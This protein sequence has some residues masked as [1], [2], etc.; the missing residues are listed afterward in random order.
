[1]KKAIAAF[2]TAVLVIGMA[3]SNMANA[4]SLGSATRVLGTS[5]ALKKENV[6]RMTRAPKGYSAFCR[7]N[8]AE[9]RSGGANSVR[10]D[11]RLMGKLIEVNAD[12]NRSIRWTRD[13]AN[14]WKVGTRTGDCEDYALTKRSKLMKLGFPASALRMAI[15]K[16]RKGDGHAVLVVKTNKGDYVLDNVHNRIKKRE[17]TNYRWVGIASSNPY[18]WQLL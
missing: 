14:V 2:A 10:L 6:L 9:C 13:R 7:S 11:S 12:V 18:R 4:A 16:T 1:M 17:H 5:P 3:S 15:V 8:P